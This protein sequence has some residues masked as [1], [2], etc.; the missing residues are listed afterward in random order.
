MMIWKN[1]EMLL[2]DSREMA[3]SVCDALYLSNYKHARGRL[4]P[5]AFW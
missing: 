3:S 1:L 4:E 5:Y 2:I